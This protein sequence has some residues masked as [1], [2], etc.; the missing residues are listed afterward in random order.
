MRIN[1]AIPP[2]SQDTSSSNR[3]WLHV[4]VL[5]DDPTTLDRFSSLA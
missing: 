2:R 5:Y 4:A 3:R 1:N